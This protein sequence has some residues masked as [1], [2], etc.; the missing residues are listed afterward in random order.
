M[1][2]LM[3]MDLENSIEKMVKK[4]QHK[5]FSHDLALDTISAF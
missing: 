5:L 4:W 1:A 3:Q 2:E